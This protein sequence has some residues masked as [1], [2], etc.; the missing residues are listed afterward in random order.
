ME[1]IYIE[2]PEEGGLEKV[3]KSLGKNPLPPKNWDNLWG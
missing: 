3:R 2:N 1:K